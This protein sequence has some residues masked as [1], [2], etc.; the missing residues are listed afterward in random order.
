MFVARLT[1][2]LEVI[3]CCLMKQRSSPPP[4]LPPTLT[5]MIAENVYASYFEIPGEAVS[6]R[7][8]QAS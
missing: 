6:E 5:T 3:I 1:N 8:T 4:P 2:Y 7:F